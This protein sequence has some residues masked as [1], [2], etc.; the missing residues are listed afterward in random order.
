[1]KSKKKIRLLSKS[2]DIIK[3][4]LDPSFPGSLSGIFKFVKGLQQKKI[5]IDKSQIQDALL[6]EWTYT[7]H[8]PVSKKF[9]TRRVIVPNQNH[10]FQIDLVDMS[11]FSKF[12]DSFR[13]ILT[14]IDVFSK[15]A[16][17][18]PVKKKQ[19]VDIVDAMKIVFE[20]SLPKFI[21]ADQGT[22]F[23]NRQFRDLLDKHNISLYHSF[24]SKK[25][26]VV[27]RFNRTLK[28]RMWR[29][30]SS[31]NASERYIDILPKL[32]NSYN[33]SY[34]R[35]I[36][37]NPSQV[38]KSNNSI[39]FKNLYGFD[40]NDGDDSFI[41]P[42]FNIGDLVRIV[43]YKRQFEKGYT[44]NWTSEAFII[45]KVM[46]SVP[47]VYEIKDTSGEIIKGKFYEKELMKILPEEIPKD[48]YPIEVID[49]K[50]DKSGKLVLVKVHWIGYDKSFDQWIHPSQLE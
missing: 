7:R 23:F 6:K 44:P 19:A 25:A 48:S 50:R 39:V 47:P 4:Y 45:S 33:N 40:K 32:V 12:N 18:I 46:P 41:Q 10:T 31:N 3:Q 27:E 38:S 28:E 29:Y 30:F 35:S 49:E 17:A 34:H 43:K 14:C 15:Y 9:M 21:H 2:E 42:R 24:S 22:E 20:K 11:M 5:K 1:M 26:S 16:W 37:M 8:R 36:K 13:Y